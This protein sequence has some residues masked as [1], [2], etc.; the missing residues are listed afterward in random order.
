MIGC[1]SFLRDSSEIRL[2]NKVP[3]HVVGDASLFCG[4]QKL[5]ETD[6]Q[7]SVVGVGVVVGFLKK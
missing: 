5:L 4:N 1:K 2:G 3:D 6:G 7:F